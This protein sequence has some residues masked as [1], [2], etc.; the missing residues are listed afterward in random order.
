MT[1]EGHEFTRGWKARRWRQLAG[2][3]VAAEVLAAARQLR[4]TGHAG[5]AG[6]A[7]PYGLSAA[8]HR[9]IN[10]NAALFRSCVANH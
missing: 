3:A 9:A 8:A 7:L 6:D 2:R 5:K 4:S 1:R 10:T